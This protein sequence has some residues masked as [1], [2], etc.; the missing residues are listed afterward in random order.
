MILPIV[1]FGCFIG[2]LAALII[3]GVHVI[4]EDEKSTPH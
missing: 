2:S 3:A 4:K 1:L